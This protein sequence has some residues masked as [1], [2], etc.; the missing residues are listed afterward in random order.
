MRLATQGKIRLY[1]IAYKDKPED[2]ARFLA[3]L[4]NPYKAVGI[5][6]DG[7]VGLDFGVYGVPETY[8]LDAAGHIRK[9]FVGPLN[10][11]AVN[12]ELLP[13]LRQLGGS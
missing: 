10:E 5:D 9:R 2:S 8:V 1:G 12:K 11:A 4:G 13:M 7:R 3:Q 6:R